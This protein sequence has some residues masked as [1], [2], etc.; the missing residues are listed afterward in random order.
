MFSRA[1][2]TILVCSVMLSTAGCKDNPSY[3]DELVSGCHSNPPSG[4]QPIREKDRIRVIEAIEDVTNPKNRSLELPAGNYCQFMSVNEDE[5]CVLFM[6]REAAAG[7]DV[8]ICY[9]NG[10]SK[11]DITIGE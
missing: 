6:L 9:K 11:P 2:T 8:Q 5:Q 4:Y 3:I 1:V 7:G 10:S